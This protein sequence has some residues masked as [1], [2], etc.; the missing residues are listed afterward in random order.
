M[1]VGLSMLFCLNK[2]LRAALKEVSQFDIEHLEIVDEGLHELDSKKVELIERFVRERDLTLSVHGPFADINIAST[3]PLI[4]AAII[5]RL[6][7]SMRLS[8]RLN[9]EFWI[10]H[11]GV[12]S[13]VSDIFPGL[14]WEINMSSVR[15]LLKEARRYGI[16]ILIENTPRTFP[17]L[18][19]YAEDLKIFYQQLGD[20]GR[21]LG[22]AFDVGH[23][24]ICGQINEMIRLFYDKIVHTHLHDNNGSM[25]THMGIGFGSI[26]WRK[27]INDLANMGYRGALV[28]ESIS[29]VRESIDALKRLIGK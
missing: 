26:D 22:I 11:P 6:K 28:V 23:A 20:E 3:S 9:P 1:R 2:P 8:A 5:R 27:L 10:F 13:A 17:F 29:N 16:K 7:K 4:R 19:R 14:D 21:D 12:R 25:D 15:E 18:I 24:N